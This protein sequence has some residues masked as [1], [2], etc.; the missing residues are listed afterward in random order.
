MT[1][2]PFST[3][4]TAPCQFLWDLARDLAVDTNLA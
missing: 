4:S 3:T 1:A 2:E